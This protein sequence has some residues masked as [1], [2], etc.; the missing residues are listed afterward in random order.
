M[1]DRS[2][3]RQDSLPE[4][5]GRR[6]LVRF[7]G[8]ISSMLYAVCFISRSRLVVGL[9]LRWLA[10]LPIKLRPTLASSSRFSDGRSSVQ[11]K[12]RVLVNARKPPGNSLWM[13]S[14]FCTIPV[15]GGNH[16]SRFRL[17]EELVRNASHT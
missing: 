15:F 7:L 6:P 16:A 2:R 3:L 13:R 14:N 10:R 5:K 1:A 12:L 8:T 4:A 11:G 17:A 9:P